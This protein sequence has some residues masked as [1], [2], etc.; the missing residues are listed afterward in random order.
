MRARWGQE[1]PRAG[2]VQDAVARVGVLLGRGGGG[3]DGLGEVEKEVTSVLRDQHTRFGPRGPTVEE[4]DIKDGK[5][6][7]ETMPIAKA[8]R[9]FSLITDS[10]LFLNTFKPFGRVKNSPTFQKIRYVSKFYQISGLFGS[11]K[12][13]L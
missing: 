6:V 1:R 11:Q 2:A 5:D 10:I 9:A 12:G 13:L 3:E 8:H 4:R 7:R